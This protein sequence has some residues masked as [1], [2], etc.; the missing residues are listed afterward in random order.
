MNTEQAKQAATTYPVI[1]KQLDSA[2]SMTG[3]YEYQDDA[4]NPIY[5]RIRLDSPNNSDS[6]WIRPFYFDGKEWALQEPKFEKGKKPLYLLPTIKKSADNVVCY[7]V[8]GEKC[9]DA[10]A[11]LGI[12]ATTSGS[13]TSASDADWSCLVGRQV[14]IWP[15]NDEQGAAYANTVAKVLLKL[16]C[17]V[18]LVDIAKLNLPPKGDCYDWLVANPSATKQDIKA[19]PLVEPKTITEELGT[20]RLRAITVSE[21]LQFEF[22]AHEYILEPWLTTQSLNM[23]FGY[24]GVGKTHISLGIAYA[25]AS[26][27]SILKWLAPKPRGVLFIDGEMPGYSLQ[28]R[29]AEIIANADKEFAPNL[30][31]LTPDLQE[32][33]MPDLA[34][35]EGQRRVENHITDETDLI[36]VDNISCLVRSGKE[37]EGESWLPI[38]EWALKLRAMGKSVL[39]IHHSNKAGGQR[40]TSRK[41]DVLDNVICLKH[42][43]GHTPE[44][45]ALFEVHFEK[46]RH[47]YGED[48]ASFEAQLFTDNTGKQLWQVKL[49]EQSTYEKVISLATEGLNQREIADE[50]DIHKS[51]VS[52]HIKNA[53]TQGELKHTLE[54]C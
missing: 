19:L 39:F 10:L 36:I 12:V 30:M 20:S 27:G 26:G 14:I 38:Q 25:V 2:W 42:P 54:V 4:G 37:N 23:I 28:K 35:V 49:L 48:A 5:W 7:I 22:K 43:I 9:A 34:T 41:E 21:L 1:K 29:M 24:R 40:G 52:R 33:G 45:G 32:F 8:E 47:L 11:K 51:N 13:A 44:Q 53:K 15:D 17:K 18:L 6:K 16:G 31:F 50:L 3:F 46:A